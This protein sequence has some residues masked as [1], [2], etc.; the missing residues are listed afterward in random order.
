M[1]LVHQGLAKDFLFIGY[2]LLRTALGRVGVL[3]Q[4]IDVEV[5]QITVVLELLGRC[6]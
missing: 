6:L 2:L 4:C 1:L 5:Y 3:T